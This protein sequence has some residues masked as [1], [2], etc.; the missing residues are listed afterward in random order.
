MAVLSVLGISIISGLTNTRE[1]L[2]D[3]AKAEMDLVKANLENLLNPAE[4]QVRYLAELIYRGQIDSDDVQALEHSLLAGLAGSSQIKGLVF[5]Y[6]NLT[7]IV[8]DR[9]T[10]KTFLF[11]NSGDPITAATVSDAFD[12]RTGSW[13]RLVYAPDAGETVLSFRQPI[14]KENDLIGILFAAVPV[15]VISKAIQKNGLSEDEDRFILYGKDHVLTQDAYPVNSD[16]V[17]YEGVVPK[18]SEIRDPVLANIW[19]GDR[20][21]FRLFRDELGF[22]GHILD[23]NGERYQ[24]FYT[25]LEGYTDRPFIIGYRVKYEDATRE[26]RRLAMAG[27]VGLGILVLGVILAFFMG[28][29]IARPI[30]VLSNAS[31]KVSGLDFSAEA[32]LPSSRFQEIDEAAQAHATML[33]GLHWFENYVPKSLVR[34][35]MESGV[36]ASETRC[37]SVMFTDIVGFTS[38]AET[39][40]SHEVADLLNHHFEL[41]TN[42]IEAEGGTVD[43]FIGDAVMAFWGAPA[44]QEDHAERACRAAQKIDAAIHQDNRERVKAGEPPIRM[45]IGIHSGELVVGNIGSSGRINYTVVGDTVNIAQRIE[46]LGKSL[47]NQNCPSEVCTLIS[48]ETRQAAHI[49]TGVR[50]VGT[51]SVKGR[52][53]SVQVYRLER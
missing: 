33:R 19:K 52:H 14:Y 49:D 25:S 5:V 34:Q 43:K 42:C 32:E 36:A 35:L 40:S 1:L 12:H 37:V 51:H 30:R 44:H 11:D 18:L 10:E 53:K 15:S 21:P 45:R 41:V 9:R 17:T 7:T 22:D 16:T 23:V 13:Q 6:P 26:V 28:R 38:L 3:K 20:S 39:M 48:E 46:Q 24:F 47:P 29:R 27:I 4:E 31:K 2:I 8:A 50:D